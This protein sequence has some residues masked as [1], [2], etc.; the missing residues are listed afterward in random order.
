M[1][2]RP[3][4]PPAEPRIRQPAPDS[5][6]APRWFLPATAAA[7]LLTFL[8]DFRTGF[9]RDDFAFLLEPGRLP[10]PAWLLP[11]LYLNAWYRPLGRELHFVF[12]GALSGNHPAGFHAAS[13]L[14]FVLALL[15]FF[16]VAA[17]VSGP[18]AAAVA[19]VL[20]ATVPAQGLFQAWISSSQDLW[21]LFLGLACLGAVLRGRS[22]AA[23]AL[24]LGAL[25]AKE[26]AV[27]VLPVAVILSG[28]VLG[29]KPGEWARRLGGLGAVALGWALIHPL[30]WAALGAGRVPSELLGGV[31]QR[32]AL[33]APWGGLLVGLA[34][35]ARLELGAAPLQ[36]LGRVPWSAWL[37]S[38]AL[39]FVLVIALRAKSG[40]AA[41]PRRWLL[42]SAWA[43]I[44]LLPLL[45]ASAQLH[46]SYGAWGA[47]GACGLLGE[48]L[49]SIPAPAGL[50]AVAALM[51]LGLGVRFAP[52]GDWYSEWS[53]LEEDRAQSHVR[54]WMRASLPPPL[55][56]TE[57]FYLQA[58]SNSGLF[59]RK[60][61]QRLLSLDWE[62][63][64]KDVRGY[65]I[66]DYH[67]GPNPQ[68]FVLYREP[69]AVPLALGEDALPP[70]G[71]AADW[72]AGQLRLAQAF[73]GSG[74][75]D[76][77]EKLLERLAALEP[78]RAEPWTT[79]ARLALARGNVALL[80]RAASEAERR[81]P[82]SA[83][84]LLVGGLDDL[85]SGNAA[86]ALDKAR[87]AGRLDS[88][89]EEAPLLEG[90]AL[91]ALRDAA[92]AAR[93]YRE[94]EARMRGDA[95]R[96]ELE[97]RIQKLLAPAPGR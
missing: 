49:A 24:L 4:A 84:V 32:S 30:T 38:A 12:L 2:R 57:I 71:A 55:P 7:A 86:A 54:S 18:R 45:P 47:C 89:S 80:H 64:G 40:G 5:S 68:Q 58:P 41:W 14:L 39:I 61:G 97:R 29:Q 3:G 83:E 6:P 1:A 10:F 50:A 63:P 36:F 44:G 96:A 62:H 53:T 78:E 28:Q 20:W 37:G 43:L 70:A 9:L 25:A 95:R 56:H 66:R 52:Q 79:M 46:V 81:S 94:A 88:L 69:P 15:A 76:R 19:T 35:L 27:L 73:Q 31:T 60:Y 21:M 92:G 59:A 33:P 48:L 13:A 8:A 23:A 74:E 72:S 87:A 90:R 26:A 75:W 67:A 82:G 17:R 51:V 22:V 77:E 42:W 16:D 85:V 11:H 34:S 65:L 91:E 93:A